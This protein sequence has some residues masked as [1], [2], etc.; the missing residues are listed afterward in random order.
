MA[1]TAADVLSMVRAYESEAKL[2]ERISSHSYPMNPL[3]KVLHVPRSD[4]E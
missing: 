3:N 2:L 4:P 1:I